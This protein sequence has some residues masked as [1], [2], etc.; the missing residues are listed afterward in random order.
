MGHQAARKEHTPIVCDCCSQE[1]SHY[2]RW[3]FSYMRGEDEIHHYCDRHYQM[4][5]TQENRMWAHMRSKEKWLKSQ[6]E[7]VA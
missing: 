2:I 7:N 6:T 1:A 3:E 4:A 5:L